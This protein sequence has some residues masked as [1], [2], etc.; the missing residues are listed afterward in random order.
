MAASRAAGRCTVEKVLLPPF[1]PGTTHIVFLWMVSL[2]W[3]IPGWTEK[4]PHR[5]DDTAQQ[6]DKDGPVHREWSRGAE[7]RTTQLLRC[8]SK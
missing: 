6:R 7:S 3:P 4:L 1:R 5:P 8:E 2:G